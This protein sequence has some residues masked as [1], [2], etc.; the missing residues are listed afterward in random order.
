MKT[1]RPNS[2]FTREHVISRFRLPLE[3]ELCINNVGDFDLVIKRNYRT[4]RASSIMVEHGFLWTLGPVI[5]LHVVGFLHFRSGQYLCFVI[6]ESVLLFTFFAQASV[7]VW[8]HIQK[9][10]RLARA[11]CQP[12]NARRLERTPQRYKKYTPRNM[13]ISP[14]IRV[15][16]RQTTLS[17]VSPK[18][19][20]MPTWL[21]G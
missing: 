7:R 2:R 18:L 5:L 19:L 21:S 8:E 9:S 3:S 15:V 10:R 12:S 6:K 1:G 14:Y 11:I 4:K 13:S 17:C 16:E 20:T